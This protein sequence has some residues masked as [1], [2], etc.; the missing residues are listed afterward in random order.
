MRKFTL[1]GYLKDPSQKVCGE[2][3]N[4]IKITYTYDDLYMVTNVAG[5]GK[6]YD[7]KDL[8]SLPLYFVETPDYSVSM[9]SISEQEYLELR[10]KAQRYDEIK[11]M[12]I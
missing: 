7:K 9:I 2:L 5:Y 11:D 6:V 3:G 10:E 12:I 1:E 8:D 4:A